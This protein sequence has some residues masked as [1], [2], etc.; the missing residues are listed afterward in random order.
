MFFFCSAKIEIYIFGVPE[1]LLIHN[2]FVK[3]AD[4]NS[5]ANKS[6]RARLA[7]NKTITTALPLLSIPSYKRFL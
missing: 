2:E 7:P 1:V 6:E 4:S 5:Q 3:I